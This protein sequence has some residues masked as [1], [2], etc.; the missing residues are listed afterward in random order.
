[1]QAFSE[2]NRLRFLV[3]WVVCAQAGEW[4]R[5]SLSPLRAG[6]VVSRRGADRT[7]RR[8]T[9][10]SA[11]RK[12]KS[13]LVSHDLQTLIDRES[14]ASLTVEHCARP[15]R[16]YRHAAEL[17]IENRSVGIARSARDAPSKPSVRPK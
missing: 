14:R 10:R 11:A 4:A 8:L 12:S 6:E 1:M 15:V 7:E 9:V 16:G 2:P 3:D 17:A 13:L 5:V